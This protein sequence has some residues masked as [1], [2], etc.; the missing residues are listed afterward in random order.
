M[1][2]RLWSYFLLIFLGGEPEVVVE[3]MEA[4]LLGLVWGA[5]VIAWRFM[6]GILIG[7]SSVY[8]LGSG[9]R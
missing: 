6:G 9:R 4:P 1:K 7:D 2:D 3:A 8:F 5:E